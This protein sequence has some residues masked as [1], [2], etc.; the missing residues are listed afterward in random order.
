MSGVVKKILQKQ[1]C[2]DF[3]KY[4]RSE[5]VLEAVRYILKSLVQDYS[6]AL[7]SS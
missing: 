6:I 4:S 1:V 5:M 2:A 7:L 3:L